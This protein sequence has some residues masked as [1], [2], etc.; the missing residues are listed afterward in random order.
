M[1]K[2]NP[3]PTLRPITAAMIIKTGTFG[4]AGEI[5]GSAFSQTFAGSISIPRFIRSAFK[6]ISA[7][8]KIFR[9]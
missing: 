6:L 9:S 4:L 5:E 3:I 2:A 7:L 8:S 1:K